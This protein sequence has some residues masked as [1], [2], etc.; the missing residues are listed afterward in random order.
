MIAPLFNC[1][2]G[3]MYETTKMMWVNCKARII[4]M[5]EFKSFYTIAYCDERIA[6][7]EAAQAMK[8]E[9]ARVLEHEM[10]RFELVDLADAMRS[11]WQA[12]KQY[13]SSVY[14]VKD[15]REAN[16]RAAGWA[17]Y[18]RASENNWVSV[19]DLISNGSNYIAEH[20]AALS[21]NGNMPDDFQTAFDAAGDAFKLKLTDYETAQQNAATGTDAKNEAN[22][23]VYQQAIDMGQD[24]QFVFRK[25]E[26]L[27]KQFS[28]EAVSERLE[29]TGT[30]TVVV[31]LKDAE[32]NLVIEKFVVTNMETS[33]KVDSVN[34]RAE[35]GQQAATDKEGRNYKVVADGYAEKIINVVLNAGVKKIEK[36]SLVPLISA[37]AKAE[38][39]ETASAAPA[40]ELVTVR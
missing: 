3:L 39:E 6:E 7:I 17:S 32:S 19:K 35:M 30:G 25:E 36:V 21:A 40:P 33:R 16:W 9:A 14:K 26:S 22:N 8:S 34:G 2:Q 20:K 13:I 4:E 37:A 5:G 18:E 10:L 24:G 11:K 31:E 23:D 29:P 15:V 1:T 28:F 38:I 27:R 12:L